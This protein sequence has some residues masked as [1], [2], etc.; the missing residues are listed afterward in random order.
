MSAPPLLY[1]PLLLVYRAK[2]LNVF[3]CWCFDFSDFKTGIVNGNR[4]CSQ[5][6]CTKVGD[7]CNPDFS[8]QAN[9][10]ITCSQ[11]CNNSETCEM[12]AY[13]TNTRVCSL[14]TC[15]HCYY[16]ATNEGLAVYF[17]TTGNVR[18]DTC[19]STFQSHRISKQVLGEIYFRF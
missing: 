6:F 10:R 17:C 14:Y 4:V 16:S 7:G 8:S 13:H 18:T 15:R 9:D 5:R 3:L 11:R 2:Y 1:E 12:V 19:T